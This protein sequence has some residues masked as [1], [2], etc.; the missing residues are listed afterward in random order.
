VRINGMHGEHRRPAPSD[1]G[2]TRLNTIVLA[3]GAASIIVLAVI[4]VGK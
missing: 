4:I 1:Q 2:E 3:I